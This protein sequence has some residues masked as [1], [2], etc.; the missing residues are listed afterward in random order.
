[1]NKMNWFIGSVAMAIGIVVG[2]V[3]YALTATAIS[4]QPQFISFG[5]DN[6]QPVTSTVPNPP[7]NQGPQLNL[8]PNV[9]NP[10]DPTNPTPSTNNLGE[11]P[12]DPNSQVGSENTVPQEL[13]DEIINNYKQNIA[14]FF[15]AWKSPDMLTFRSNLGKAYKGDLYERH[16]KQAESFI[17]QSV[18]LEVSEIDFKDVKVESAN[19]NSATITAEYSYVAQDYDV[20]AK[21]PVGDKS[22]HSVKVRVNMIKDGTRW[23]I[24]GESAL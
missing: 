18:G 6:T 13:A 15:E 4:G 9:L 1:M 20:V 19:Q 14:N 7:T 8:D 3:G 5:G 11:N 23:L 17:L 24:T 12:L 22:E 16:A 21:A 2:V 10:F